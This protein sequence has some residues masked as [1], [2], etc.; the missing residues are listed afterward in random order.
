[1]IIF[2][3]VAL[4]MTQ[5]LAALLLN[6]HLSSSQSVHQPQ[7]TRLQIEPSS[8]SPELLTLEGVQHTQ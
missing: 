2:L 5:C 4:A 8:E 3:K 1:M 6:C 7:A